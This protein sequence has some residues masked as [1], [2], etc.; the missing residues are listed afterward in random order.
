MQSKLSLQFYEDYNTHSLTVIDRS[1]YNQDITASCERLLI[2]LPGFTHPITIDNVDKN[3]N[4][5]LTA[6]DFKLVNYHTCN[7]DMMDLPDGLYIV[8]YSICP[9]DLVYVEYN[10]LRQTKVYKKY[11]SK[12]C[13]LQLLGCEGNNKT[14]EIIKKL[15]NIEMYLQAAKAYVEECGAPQRGLELQEYAIK[16]LDKINTDC[17]C[18]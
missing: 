10:Y 2:T 14:A 17:G 3:F 11:F 9:N 12:L 4:R 18:K 1:I 13:S 5:A 7:C 6:Q 8:N 16:L 15:K